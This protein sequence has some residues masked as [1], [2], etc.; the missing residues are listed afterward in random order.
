MLPIITK[1]N[2]SQ[3]TWVGLWLRFRI[4]GMPFQREMCLHFFRGWPVRKI[5]HDTMRIVLHQ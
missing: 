5:P 1:L 2:P 4:T 3:Q